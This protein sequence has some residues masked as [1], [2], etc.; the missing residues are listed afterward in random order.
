[1][2]KIFSAK[3]KHNEIRIDAVAVRDDLRGLSIGTAMLKYFFDF[4]R[5]EGFEKTY[6]E[7][8]DT[9]PRAKK[10]YERLGFV[11]KKTNRF[12]FLTAGAGFSSQDIMYRQL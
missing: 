7:V 5:T 3:V 1:V 6:L 11:R 10:L 8:V 9:N 12:Y 4:A 2:F